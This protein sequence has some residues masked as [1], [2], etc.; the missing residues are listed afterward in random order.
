MRFGQVILWMGVITAMI[1][2]FATNKS[3]LWMVIHG[4]FGWLYLILYAFGLV[5]TL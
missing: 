4:C 5:E 2:S 3:I 1:V